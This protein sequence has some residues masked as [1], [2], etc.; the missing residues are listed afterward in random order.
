[1]RDLFGRELNYLRLSI[2]DKCNLRCR[3]CMPS[4]N[5]KEMKHGDVLSF[6]EI[7]RLCRIFADLGIDKIR[8]T[9]GEPLIRKDV[10]HLIERLKAIKGIENVC[11]T[12]NGCFLEENADRLCNARIDG[13]NV[14]LD[15]LKRDIFRTLTGKDELSKVLKGIEK[16]YD[17]G[18]K[19]KLNCVPIAGINDN[20]LADLAGMA[21]D[22]DID[23]RFIE[24]MPIGMGKE[25]K[26]IDR[27]T[28]IK[29]LEGCYGR[30]IGTDP[31]YKGSPAAY[32]K[33]LGFRGRIGFIS[34]MSHRFCSECNRLRLTSGGYLKYCL[35]YPDGCDL[36]SPL[37]D[38]KSDGYIRDLIEGSVINKPKEHRFNEDLVNTECR[39]MYE[40]GG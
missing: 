3:Y 14:S 34:P 33:A 23:V 12:T 19:V 35:Q 32:Y 15:T 17:L 27:E 16:A 25:H 13:I 11:L 37:R 26:G 9:G 18:I 21:K 5:I 22:K 39:R 29:E 6:E 7:E 28:I 4:S 10:V 38:H 24:L 8:L 1:M 30:L 36:K 2:T 20:E 40:I 31:D